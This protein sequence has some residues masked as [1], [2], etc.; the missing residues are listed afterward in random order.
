M[1]GGKLKDE[2]T[3]LTQTQT[4]K[5]LDVPSTLT[6]TH[7]LSPEAIDLNI[8]VQSHAHTITSVTG[9]GI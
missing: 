3:L 6:H 5:K 2:L 1:L 7:T 4:Y 8:P 9:H